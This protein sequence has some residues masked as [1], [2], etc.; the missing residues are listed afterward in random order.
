MRIIVTVQL[1][2]SNF[3]HGALGPS[4]NTKHTIAVKVECDHVAD[5]RPK[6]YVETY[7]IGGVKKYYL[8]RNNLL[9][10]RHVSLE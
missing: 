2:E 6:L 7:A 3:F 5:N 8:Q 1:Y 10:S 9:E 4:K